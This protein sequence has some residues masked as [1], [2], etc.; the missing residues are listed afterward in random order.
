MRFLLSS[1]SCFANLLNVS[2][3]VFRWISQQQKYMF[4]FQDTDWYL[5]YERSSKR[6]ATLLY[7]WCFRAI[8]KTN[9]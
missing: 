2:T 9:V 8:V 6:T 7:Q 3:L 5:Q 4:A 1:P